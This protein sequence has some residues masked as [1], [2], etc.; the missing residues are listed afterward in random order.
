MILF[1]ERSSVSKFTYMR[2]YTYILRN[3]ETKE[4]IGE[5][6]WGATNIGTLEP[7]AHRLYVHNSLQHENVKQRYDA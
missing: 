6:L 4:K 2:R 1:L 7:S 3:I 5:G